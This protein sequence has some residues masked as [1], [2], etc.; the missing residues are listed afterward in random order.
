[1]RIVFV[2]LL[3]YVC[4]TDSRERRIPNAACV[5]GL[6]AALVWHGLTGPGSGL[7]S[8]SDAGA[9]G[10]T[11]SLLGALAAFALFLALHLVRVMGA[12]DVKLMGMLGAWFGLSS[13]PELVLSVFLAGGALVVAR[14][15]FGVSARSVG[16]N[17]RTIVSGLRPTGWGA[18][19]EP[20]ARFDPRV[21]TADRM[22]YAWALALGAVALAV[23]D[24]FA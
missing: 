21:D 7:F 4:V 23:R 17:L 8:A 5:I 13:V 2:G 3:L 19:G 6:F 12:G 15:A 22:P 14:I 24:Y 18:G 9:L 10:L 16:A 11:S 20:L 1:M